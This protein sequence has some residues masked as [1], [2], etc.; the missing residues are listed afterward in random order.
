[1]PTGGP[2]D[3]SNF[4]ENFQASQN[5]ARTQARERETQIRERLNEALR[6]QKE[7][8]EN[9]EKIAQETMKGRQAEAS[10]QQAENELRIV[11][12]RERQI[13]DSPGAPY[14]R[15]AATYGKILDIQERIADAQQRVDDH[16][17]NLQR[18]I[19]D[20]D[21][22]IRGIEVQ[23]AKPAGWFSKAVE[24]KKVSDLSKK[25]D[26]TPD[27]PFSSSEYKRNIAAQEGADTPKTG[28]T[29]G[30]SR[31]SRSS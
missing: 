2:G 26:R 4:I 21:S 3:S 22:R 14:R 12:E 11:Q 30:L 7:M 9:D 27:I 17:E 31:P 23:N 16:R 20:R 28:L 29:E 15:G 6:I 1:M 5:R 25:P 8:R 24:A 10:R 19:E 13:Q 18:L